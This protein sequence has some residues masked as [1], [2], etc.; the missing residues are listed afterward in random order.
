MEVESS[1]AKT[2]RLKCE[3]QLQKL[4]AE[5]LETEKKYVQDLQQACKDYL[6]LTLP[7]RYEDCHSLD[8]NTSLDSRPLKMRR[9]S[10]SQPQLNRALVDTAD[11]PFRDMKDMMANIVNIKEYHVKILLPRMKRAIHSP[12]DI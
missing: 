2:G 6:P 12:R 11:I 8:R 5:L 7:S 4:L 3:S 10:V 9:R 1:I